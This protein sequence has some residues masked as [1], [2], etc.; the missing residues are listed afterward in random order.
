MDNM[1]TPQVQDHHPGMHPSG[2]GH[3]QGHDG[4][5]HAADQAYQ[6]QGGMAPGGVAHMPGGQAYHPPGGMAPGAMP[7]APAQHGRDKIDWSPEVWH[8]IDAAVNEEIRRSRVVA[9]FLPT[10]YVPAKTTTIPADVVVTP[11]VAAAEST[12]QENAPLGTLYVDET[13]TRRVNELWVEWSLTP[14]HVE[15]EAASIHGAH[16]RPHQEHLQHHQHHQH[17]QQ[18]STG[19]SLA[20]RA[21]NILAQV[22]DMVLCQGQNAFQSALIAGANSNIGY[23]FQTSD[24]GLL[25]LLLPGGTP[26]PLLGSLPADHFVTVTPLTPNGFYQERTPA[27]VANA[28][29]ILEAYGHYGPFALVL[30]TK[31][32]GDAHSPLP[33]TLITPADILYKFMNAGFHGTGSLPPF[34][35]ATPGPNAG[36]LYGGLWSG[37]G[38]GGIATVAVTNGGSGYPT[39]PAVTIAPPP[40][41]AATGV[42]AVSPSGATAGQILSVTMNASGNS[43]YSASSPPTVTFAPPPSGA[44][45]ATAQGT[46]QVSQAGVI[47]GVN[48]TNPGSGYS[49]SGPGPTVTFGAATATATISAGIVT[50]VTVT[51]PSTGYTSPPTP[52]SPPAWQVIIAPP[53]AVG[54][55]AAG[56]QATAIVPLILYTGFVVSLGGNTMDIVRGKMNAHDDVV[57]RFEQKDQNG[58][59]RFRVIER[60]ALRLKDITAVVQLQFLSA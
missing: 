12:P 8:R 47:T 58:W 20:T 34:I 35:P 11:A 41:S 29:S 55:A 30:Q 52:P 49:T 4:Q 46:A 37:Y 51:N 40:S 32:F 38:T 14:A 54:G 5:A 31:P 33:T 27:A 7:H 18:A 36:G 9:K 22:E 3:P 28:F 13:A 24:L 39:A 10:V 6:A 59:Y 15:E 50:S 56:S 53:P 25:N 44:Y 60:V 1:I 16:D 23:R 17:H 43:G 45:S 48:I 21:A 42:G 26:D 19:T 2:Y 57:V